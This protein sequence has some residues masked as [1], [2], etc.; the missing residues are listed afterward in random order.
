MPKDTQLNDNYFK[1]E[2]AK[3]YTEF[4]E[5][6]EMPDNY[7]QIQNYLNLLNGMVNGKKKFSPMEMRH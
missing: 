6:S 4:N 1:N 2:V 7:L 5:M 3:L